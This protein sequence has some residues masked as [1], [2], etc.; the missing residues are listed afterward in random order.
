VLFALMLMMR[1][2]LGAIGLVSV[3][4]GYALILGAFQV[5][6]GVE[7]RGVRRIR[8]PIGA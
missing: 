1:P 4:A 7:L 5:M 8:R 2:A 6:P 3:I